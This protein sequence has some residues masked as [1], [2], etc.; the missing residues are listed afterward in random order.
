[1]QL[2][3]GPYLVTGA[4]GFVGSAVARALAGRGADVRVL[5]RPG[6][7][8]RN[9]E[10]LDVAVF[11]G[12]LQQPGT[13]EPALAGCEGLFH[14]AAD[15]RLWTRDPDAMFRANV[16]GS[17]AILR[18]AHDAGIKRA[19]YTSSVAV[20]G[21]TP[22]HPADE[23][24]PVSYG[25]MIGVYKQ[26]KYRAEE[27]VQDVIRD[28][29]IDCVIVNPST[30]IGPRDIKPTP[31]GR[32]VLEAAAGRMPAYVDTG[33]NVAHVD[34]VA[35]GHLQ[36]FERGE[37]GRRYILGGEDMSLRDILH[38]VAAIAGV[39]PPVMQIPRAPIY[40]LAWVAEVLCRLSGKGEPFATVDGLK[41]SRKKMFF[42]SARAE[43]ELGYSHRP[44]AEALRDAV[45]WFRDNGYLG[46]S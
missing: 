28:T 23:E 33:L 29:G 7:D 5:A 34:D 39:K 6:G 42:S 31:T 43:S 45:D 16:E 25:D 32:L 24:T 35:A 3:K 14:V 10:G 15:Y 9:L 2:N 41:M 22:G 44:G 21:I 36:A 19:V 17:R 1:M 11:E 40:P 30:P 8:R 13:L 18:A 26:S 27:A 4:T 46:G 38:T 37:R 20:L 12:D